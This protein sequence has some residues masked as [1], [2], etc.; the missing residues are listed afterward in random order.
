MEAE[1]TEEGEPSGAAEALAAKGLLDKQSPLYRAAVRIQARYR[2]YVVRKVCL[3][4]SQ[5][6]VV[7]LHR[8]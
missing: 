2:G 6:T 1:E 3:L 7:Q 5:T 8:R 4:L